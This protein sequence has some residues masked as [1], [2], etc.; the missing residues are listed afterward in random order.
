MSASPAVAA[1]P[2]LNAKRITTVSVTILF[3]AWIVNYVDRLA[4]TT[5][6]PSL[7]K[8]FDLDHTQQGLILTVFFAIYALFQLPG[9]FL[10][11]RIGAKRTMIAAMVSWSLFTGLTGLVSSFG[12]LLI[13]RALFGVTE[14]LYPGASM[15]AVAERTQPHN[16]MT[17][18]GIV[19]SANTLGA[20]LAPLI[21]APVI[22]AVGW[23]HT[24]LAVAGAGFLMAVVIWWALPAPL[25]EPT[26][27]EGDGERVLTASATTDVST[28]QL[29]RSGALWRFT[30]LFGG[31]DLVVWGLLSWVPSYLQ[32][33]R[34]VSITAS[35]ALASI[36]NFCAT[37]S[38]IAGGVLFDRYFYGRHRLLIIPS[39]AIGGVLLLF[40]AYATSTVT[41]ITYQSLAMLVLFMSFMPIFG[42]PLRMLPRNVVGR[43]SALINMGGQLAGAV[44]P[45]IM[46]LLADHVS[47]AAA[48]AFLIF[49]A[50]VAIAAVLW[51]PQRPEELRTDFAHA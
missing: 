28:A 23:R 27:A 45:F 25:P 22:T 50:V 21:A 40:M 44:A 32:T 7:A 35:G 18:N 31:F 2:S 49:G 33:E 9:G 15:K 42:L 5:A 47:F 39:C 41:F 48:F 43:A 26:A 29:L 51:A 4:I 3:V 46:G 11:D 19:T 10:A 38:M 8:E 20:A 12:M 24:F 17:A 37:L 16:R 1:R 6:L 34:G 30:L 36:P 14:G 13:V